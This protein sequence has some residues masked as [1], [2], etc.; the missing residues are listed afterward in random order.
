MHV[1]HRAL[2]MPLLIAMVKKIQIQVKL[3]NE[4]RNIGEVY[5]RKNICVYITIEWKQL[6]TYKL[7]LDTISKHSK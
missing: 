1:F 4:K 2:N 5:I 7:N 6:K 3:L